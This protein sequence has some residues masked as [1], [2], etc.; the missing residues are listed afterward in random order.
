MLVLLMLAG[1]GGQVGS[2][3]STPDKSGGS[4]SG[5]AATVAASPVGS[6]GDAGTGNT[7]ASAT[8]TANTAGSASSGAGID[9]TTFNVCGLLTQDEVVNLMPNV[10]YDGTS[11]DFDPGSGTK[12]C[13]YADDERTGFLQLTVYTPNRWDDEAKIIGENPE[14]VS[15]LGDEAVTETLR[16][17]QVLAVLVRGKAAFLLTVNP[18]FIADG[19]YDAKQAR[20]I[21]MQ[22]AAK[23]IPRLR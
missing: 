23:I 6:G 14:A 3:A 5:G 22:L 16:N 20:D 2:P 8:S 11:S 7:I 9:L 10:K 17:A 19:K 12:T 13:T 4:Q 21:A 15:G 1:C 18:A